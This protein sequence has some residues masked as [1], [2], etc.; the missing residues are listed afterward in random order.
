MR[1]GLPGAKRPPRR[2]HHPHRPH[3]ALAV[4][5][6]EA[7]RRHRVMFG[8]RGAEARPALS[9]MATNAFGVD[10]AR[11]IRNR[12]DAVDRGMEIQTCATN[13]DRQRPGLPRRRDRLRRHPQP[14]RHRR[15]LGPVNDAV[16]AMWRAR[17]F[18]LIGTRRQNTEVAVDL[19]RVRIDH[20]T[21]AFFRQR[22]RETRFPGGR[23]PANHHNGPGGGFVRHFRVVSH[24]DLWFILFAVQSDR[25]Q[26]KVHHFAVFSS[27]EH[28]CL[29]IEDGLARLASVGIKAE[30]P[31]ARWLQHDRAWDVPITGSE[32]PALH[33]LRQQVSES[34]VDINILPATAR[35]KKLLLADMDS[36]IITSE[37]LDDMAR[38]AGLADAIIPI[39]ERSMRGELDFEAALDER[40]A[41]LRGHPASLIDRALAEAE[42]TGGARK[43]VRTMRAHGAACFLVSGGFTAITGPV[44]AQCEFNDHHANVLETADGVLTGTVAK[45]VL[46]RES[47]LRF[48]DHYC[49]RLG[50]TRAEAAC[51]G[52][53]AND[54]AMLQAAG[55]GVALKGKPLL[56]AAIPVQLNHTDLTGLLYL[57]GYTDSDFA[58][59]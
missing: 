13:K 28:P 32:P 52:D 1:I 38:I 7:V 26:A 3:K 25:G 20:H 31:A 16:E 54:L 36:T 19:H 57:Q 27:S 47:K 18:G 43:L 24:A 46:D 48:L 50:I 40:V 34:G 9:S 14:G 15:A 41:L 23:R 33:D 5:I 37:S 56:R 8:Q 12:G 55:L 22:E 45:P 21:A 53:G 44:A 4:A 11:H 30:T 59:R 6:M 42:L 17:H 29:A 51:I 49:A 35:R 10:I 39:T 58:E 2:Q